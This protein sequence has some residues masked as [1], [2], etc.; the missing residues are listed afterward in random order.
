METRDHS[1]AQGSVDERK[2]IEFSMIRI[3]VVNTLHELKVQIG[4][5]V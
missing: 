5:L 4:A 1:T 3:R 2:Y